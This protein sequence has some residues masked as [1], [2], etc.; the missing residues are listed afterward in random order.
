MKVLVEERVS[1]DDYIPGIFGT[2]DLGIVSKGK[3]YIIDAKFGFKE[4]LPYMNKQ[5]SIYALGLF[6]Q[7]GE[8]CGI[9]KVTLGI[10]QPRIQ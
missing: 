10:Y 3:L 5:L 7:Y 9:E 6:S 2:C 1:I 8:A 4:V